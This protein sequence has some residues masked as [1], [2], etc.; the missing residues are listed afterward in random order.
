M[1]KSKDFT[2]A[3]KTLGARDVS[4]VLCW[5]DTYNLYLGECYEYTSILVINW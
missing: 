1:V 3:I 5:P 4:L 2:M